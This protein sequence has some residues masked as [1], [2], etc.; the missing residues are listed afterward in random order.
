VTLLIS[1]VSLEGR[2]VDIHI[3]HGR[4]TAVAPSSLSSSSS[5]QDGDSDDPS[6]SGGEAASVEPDRVIDGRGLHAFP[7]LKNGHT[8]AAMTLFRGWGDDLPLMEWLETHIWP[9][10]EH[11]RPEDVY[12]GTRLAIV[13][14]IRSGCTYFNDMY[15]HADQVR[16]AVE[17][18]GVRA[19]LGSVFVDHGDDGVADRWR[20]HVTRQLETL[21]TLP[22]RIQVA[23]APHAIYTV[24]PENLEW[25]GKR[26][27]DH[28]LLLHIHLS[29]TQE[30]V[31]ACVAEHGVRPVHLLDQLGLVGPHLV[32]AHGI[33][34]DREELTLLADAGATLVT[35]PTANLK[36]AVGGIFDYDAAREAGVRVALGTD[37]PGS[38]NNLD[39]LEE[40]K[41]AAL[42]QK[43]RAGDAT[44]LPAAEALALATTHA[45][46]AFRLGKGTIEPG[47]PA[48]LILVDLAGAATRPG[49]DP[50][51]DLVYA[52][53]GSAVH[54]TICDGRVLMH[55]R[56]IEV[57]DEAGIVEEAVKAARG[58]VA[59]VNGARTTTADGV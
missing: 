57:A 9:A 6:I 45:S 14:M 22:D 49:H 23:I 53:N 56:V 26:A 16:R 5:W 15:W 27:L 42:V 13:E 41:V 40:M 24:S 35:N 21:D 17:E 47:Q 44:S 8:H 10:E 55:D 20:G 52:A 19:H 11:M 28:D 50:V 33:F 18:L 43:H 25:L 32:G 12:H 37:G 30:E 7:S 58:L 59:R 36:L 38:N 39:M 31:D 1:S 34:L 3:D 2:A 54:T 4:I 51:S 29:E 48:D 46:E